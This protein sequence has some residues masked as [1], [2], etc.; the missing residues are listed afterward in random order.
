MTAD[1]ETTLPSL[2][3]AVNRLLTADRKSA[4]QDRG[5]KF[6]DAKQQAYERARTEATYGWDASPI[7]LPRL[8]AEVWAQVK[9]ED[10]AGGIGGF[11]WNYEKHYQRNHGGSAA[12]EG[13]GAPSAVGAALAHRKHGPALCPPPNRR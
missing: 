9:N 10:W 11:E 4:L 13:G 2:T 1:P 12:G 6:A 7:S 3:E 5:K 8:S